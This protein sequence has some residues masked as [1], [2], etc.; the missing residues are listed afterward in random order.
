MEVRGERDDDKWKRCRLSKGKV[1]LLVAGC[2]PQGKQMWS[3]GSGSGL[4]GWKV[5][6]LVVEVCRRGVEAGFGWD[7]GVRGTI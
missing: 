3:W 7:G 4:K 6:F 1:D 2:N 5:R